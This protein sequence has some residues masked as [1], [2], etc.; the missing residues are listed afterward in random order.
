MLCSGAI[1]VRLGVCFS[2]RV[3]GNGVCGLWYRGVAQLRGLLWLQVLWLVPQDDV[4][5]KGPNVLPCP[6][7]LFALGLEQ[8]A[9]GCQG[10]V[11]YGA[12]DA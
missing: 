7:I 6:V 4:M 2:V 5:L 10:L 1:V 3:Q 8:V 9:L 11:N 12:R